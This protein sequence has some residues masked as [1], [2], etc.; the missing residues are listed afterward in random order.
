MVILLYVYFKP[1]KWIQFP[2]IL[3]IFPSIGND[4]SFYTQVFLCMVHLFVHF[5]AF[6]F[7][8]CIQNY[9]YGFLMLFSL[10][11]IWKPYP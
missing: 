7:D 8:D 6:M 2:F 9:T 5:D 4:F 10:V 3:H 11:Q 1:T